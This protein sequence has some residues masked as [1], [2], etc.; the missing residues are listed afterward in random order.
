VHGLRGWGLPGTHYR[1]LCRKV[2][3]LVWF[4]LGWV[5]IFV[6]VFLVV[7]LEFE[8]GASHLCDRSSLLKP[9][10]QP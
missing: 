6:F 7:V 1:E 5:F 3:C 10:H 2:F 9:H 4:G 8:L